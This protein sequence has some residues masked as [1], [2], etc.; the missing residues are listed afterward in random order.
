MKLSAKQRE[1]LRRLAGE[2]R[3]LSGSFLRSV[4]FRWMHPNDVMSGEGAARLGGRFVAV[5]TRALFASGSE[6]TLLRE[7]ATRKKRLG[8]NAQ[9]DFDRYPRVIFRIDLNLDRHVSLT[10]SCRDRELERT[11]RQCLKPNDLLPSQVVGRELAALRVQAILYPSVAGAGTNVVVFLEN[12][13]R[14]NVVLFNRDAVMQEI[15][16]LSGQ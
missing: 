1:L 12:T 4:E 7:I 16:R 3:P 13:R 5:G 6:E 15:S 11:R 14:G 2:A 9:I 8:G 10:E